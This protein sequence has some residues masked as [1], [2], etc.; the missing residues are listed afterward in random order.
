[1]EDDDDFLLHG[2]EELPDD[3][4]RPSTSTQ[5]TFFAEA[6]SGVPN[7]KKR[8]LKII[9]GKKIGFSTVQDNICQTLDNPIP[10]E[11]RKQTL[12]L[13]QCSV[14][15]SEYQADSQFCLKITICEFPYFFY[16]IILL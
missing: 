1:M 3:S 12:A 9:D 7:T 8:K 2:F 10:P 16:E 13:T 11:E 15:L 5:C 14:C 6:S 4:P